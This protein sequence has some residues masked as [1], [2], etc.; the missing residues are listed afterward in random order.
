MVF[1]PVPMP[2]AQPSGQTKELA[3][4][5]EETIETYQRQAPSMSRA[6]I[7]QA[8]KLAGDR[9]RGEIG[10]RTKTVAVAASLFAALVAGV[11][12]FYVAGSGKTFPALRETSVMTLIGGAA[13]LAVLLALIKL[14]FRGD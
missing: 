4:R 7:R 14:R 3:R 9:E 8:L 13:A 2:P 12:A 5:L 1:V 10:A 6:E 11:V